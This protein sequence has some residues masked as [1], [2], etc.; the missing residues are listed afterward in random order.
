MDD[1]RQEAL[2]EI[3]AQDK[4]DRQ[5]YAGDLD[6]PPW[7]LSFDVYKEPNPDLLVARITLGST[8]R[9]LGISQ[10]WGAT[11]LK[12]AWDALFDACREGNVE[13]CRYWQ[14]E[15]A[16]RRSDF[17]GDEGSPGIGVP[18]RPI[19]PAPGYKDKKNPYDSA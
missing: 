17:Y 14:K 15:V 19:P 10:L 9:W 2:R 7:C 8:I 18:R 5:A 6:L 3:I 1:R 13:E 12:K 4:I 16:R 11:A